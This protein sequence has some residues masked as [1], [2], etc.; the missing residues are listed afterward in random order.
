MSRRRFGNIT[1]LP[2]GRYR[3]RYP[4]PDGRARNAP[5]TFATKAE[6]DRFLSDQDRDLHRGAWMDPRLRSV[7]LASYV[8][9]W[10]PHRP[11]APRTRELYGD[12]LRLHLLPQLGGYPLSKITP[13][14][15]RAWRHAR[16]QATGPTRT[17]QAYSLL[18][19]VLTTARVDGLI[20]ENPCQIKGAGQEH[21]PERPLVT[22]PDFYALSDAIEDEFELPVLLAYFAH[23]RMGELLGLRRGD[24]NLKASELR[25]ERQLIRVGGV[26]TEGPPK[27]ESSRTV[28]LLDQVVEALHDHL[29]RSGPA[30][31]TASLFVRSDGTRM[32]AHHVGRAWRRARV[33][34]G[35][36][37]F[38]FHDLRGGGLTLAS[39]S[40]ATIREV[41][42]LDGH[43]TARAAMIYQHLAAA[44]GPEI[45]AGMSPLA[46]AAQQSRRGL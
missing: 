12:L 10:L 8:A 43:K 30:L 6:A 23:L 27:A 4:G 14:T 44:R 22:L 39:Q 19:T 17:R 2:S 26:L 24:V 46:K 38:H 41:M 42:G 34:V 7:T 37:D 36:P 15:V 25:V 5:T 33:E 28:P 13:A 31:P 29:V 45:A 20:Q 35:R 11:L 1:R 9:D 16:S 18:R 40:G 21:T 3:A 32:Q